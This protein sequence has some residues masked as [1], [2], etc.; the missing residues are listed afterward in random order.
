MTKKILDITLSLFLIICAIVL[1]FLVINEK[2]ILK[3]Y[4]TSFEA[5]KNTAIELQNTLNNIFSKHFSIMENQ[6]QAQIN[7]Y[8][9]SKI[10]N[11]IIFEVGIA[12][13]AGA[14]EKEGELSKADSNEIIDQSIDEIR[15]RSERLG[16]LAKALNDVFR[17]KYLEKKI[18]KSLELKP[19]PNQKSVNGRFVT[20]STVGTL[21]V[22]TGRVENPSN[23]PYS[24]IQLKGTLVTKDKTEAKTRL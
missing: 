4:S 14:L 8:E 18:S 21:F 13:G 17:N 11:T 9:K 22:I 20:N 5:Q 10:I 3:Y 16:V 23:I 12:L 2:K 1:I 15:T 6:A 19:V 24:H 7:F